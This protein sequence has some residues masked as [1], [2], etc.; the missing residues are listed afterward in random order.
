MRLGGQLRVSSGRVIG[1]DMTAA[2]ALGAAM[3]IAPP[4]LAALLPQIEPIMTRKLNEQTEQVQR[5]G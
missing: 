3:G 1:W 5:N 2:L 4:V